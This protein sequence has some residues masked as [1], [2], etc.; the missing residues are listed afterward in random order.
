MI[1]PSAIVI[2]AIS[3]VW[4]GVFTALAAQDNPKPDVSP[5]VREAAQKP[6][7]RRPAPPA[8]STPPSPAVPRPSEPPRTAVPRPPASPHQEAGPQSR[9]SIRHYYPLFDF[10]F[11]Y[12]FPYGLYPYSRFGYPY[13]YP[14]PYPYTYPYPPSEYPFSGSDS[15][16]PAVFGE[17]RIDI[18]QKEATVFADGYFVGVVEDFDGPIEHLKLAPG[19]HH[20]EIRAARYQTLAFDV[21]VQ[22]GR[23]I[24]YRTPLELAGNQDERP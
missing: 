3:T 17:V 15:D 10:D 2:A 5:A 20:I 1:K 4:M 22:A 23:T 19:P 16:E 14:Y 13:P 11:V 24:T 8:T 9:P 7:S 21:F 12:R 6:S 18:P